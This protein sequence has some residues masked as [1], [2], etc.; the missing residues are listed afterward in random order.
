MKSFI[1]DGK[2][3][4]AIKHCKEIIKKYP[5]T[6]AAQEAKKLLEKLEK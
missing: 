5:K 1:E 6:P 3:D 4:L 2:N